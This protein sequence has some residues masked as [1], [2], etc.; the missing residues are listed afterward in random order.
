MKLKGALWSLIRK[1]FLKMYKGLSSLKLSVE[2]S[3]LSGLQTYLSHP[4]PEIRK[5]VVLIIATRMKFQK[6]FRN[7]WIQQFP[8]SNQRTSQI[9]ISS[10]GNER[11]FMSQNSRSNSKQ[12]PF[13]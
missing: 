6:S 8:L 13:N 9:V 11:A 7:A 3:H 2:E 12:L 1:I 10:Y 4:D 5:L